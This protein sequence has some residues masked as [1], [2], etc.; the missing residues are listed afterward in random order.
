MASVLDFEHE[1]A[2]CKVVFWGDGTAS[3]SDVYAKVRRQGHTTEL[4]NKVMHFVDKRGLL[5]KTVAEAHG[6][7]PKMSTP[8]LIEFYKKFGFVPKVTEATQYIYMERQPK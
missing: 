5:L 3:L 6:A 7:E 1:S 4:L 2:S 8:Q